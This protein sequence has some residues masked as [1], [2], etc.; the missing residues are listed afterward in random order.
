MP[1]LAAAGVQGGAVLLT[2][3]RGVGCQG[4]EEEEAEEDDYLCGA[5]RARLQAL[6]QLPFDPGEGHVRR[7]A[8][9]R[10]KAAFIQ[11]GLRV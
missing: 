8:A 10:D 5:P 6:H 4:L 9:C 3:Q 1:S 2:R 7:G 11:R